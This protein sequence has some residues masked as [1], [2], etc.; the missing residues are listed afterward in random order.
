MQPIDLFATVNENKKPDTKGK[1]RAVT[2]T[3]NGFTFNESYA[4]HYEQ[5]KRG[6]ELMKCE[7]I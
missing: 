7:Y 2:D 6:E 1:R 3:E 5:R 4:Q